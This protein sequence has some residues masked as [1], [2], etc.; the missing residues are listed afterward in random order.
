MNP[1]MIPEQEHAAGIANLLLRE[2][3]LRNRDDADHRKTYAELMSDE[4]LF[5]EVRERLAAVGY[6]LVQELGYLG[7]RPARTAG[8]A[9]QSRNVVGIHAGHIRLIVYFWTHLVYRELKSLRHREDAPAPGPDQQGIFEEEDED[10]AAWMSLRRVE[11]DFGDVLSQAKLWQYL[12]QLKRW[13]FIGFDKRRD[14]VWADAS[15]YVQVDRTQME[16]FVVSQ[17]R[18]L[19]REEPSDAIRDIA[20]GS[21][22]PGADDGNGEESA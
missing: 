9:C 21:R 22:P 4:R 11:T 10:A 15:L 14:R 18:R 13:R 1:G 8:N 17:A 20:I 7:V 6:E 12:S 19:G 3:A 16:D 2:G 5:V